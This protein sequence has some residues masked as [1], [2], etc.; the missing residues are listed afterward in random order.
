MSFGRLMA[1]GWIKNA[2]VLF[3]VPRTVAARRAARAAPR[4]GK[5]I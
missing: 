5:L 3:P 4:R 2:A 1:F